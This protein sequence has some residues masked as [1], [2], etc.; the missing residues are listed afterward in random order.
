MAST[1]FAMSGKNAGGIEQ[2]YPIS[3]TLAVP[4]STASGDLVCINDMVVYAQTDRD[5]DGNA[6]CTIPCRFVEKV[7]VYGHNHAGDNAVAIGDKLYADTSE[8]NKD[9]TDGKAFGYAL[10]T[11]TSGGNSEILVGFGL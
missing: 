1:R 3:L 4:A 10:G 5:S 11:V 8:I 2:A 6:V 7:K 9:S